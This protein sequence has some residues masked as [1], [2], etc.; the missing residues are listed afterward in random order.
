MIEEK[1]EE[2]LTITTPGRSGRSQSRAFCTYGSKEA[3]HKL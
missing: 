1:M 3:L 2:E